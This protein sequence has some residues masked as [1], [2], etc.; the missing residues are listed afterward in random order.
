LLAGIALLLVAVATVSA[1]LGRL[2]WR[3]AIDAQTRAEGERLAREQADTAREEAKQ[4]ARDEEAARRTANAEERRAKGLLYASQ[5]ALAQSY[6][7]EGNT[8]V[9]REKLDEAREH[10][11]TWEYRYLDR[12]MNHLDQRTL[13]GHTD[14]VTSVCFSPDGNRLASASQDYGK[15]GEVKVWDAGTGQETHTLRSKSRRR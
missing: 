12:L 8:K 4:K 1:V 15:P 11:D 6:W 2:A 9:A 7:T 3:K 10:R 14:A 13:P 5:L